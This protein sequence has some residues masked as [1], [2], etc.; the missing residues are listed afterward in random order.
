MIVQ[1]RDCVVEW[2]RVENLSDLLQETLAVQLCGRHEGVLF[3]QDV[4]SAQGRI[5]TKRLRPLHL[6]VCQQVE[7]LLVT[8]VQ[9]D[10]DGILHVD[11]HLMGVEVL[12]RL[13]AEAFLSLLRLGLGTEDGLDGREVLWERAQLLVLLDLRLVQA[14][15]S[16]AVPVA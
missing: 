12:L 1:A 13:H 15:V 3:E 2:R 9:D 5:E 7:R 4:L 6:L 14:L 8:T 10:L 11:A 16:I